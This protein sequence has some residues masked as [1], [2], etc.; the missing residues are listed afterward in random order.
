MKNEENLQRAAEAVRDAGAL[1]VCAGAGMGVDSGLPD[2]RGDKGFWK[3]YPPYERLGLGFI[4]MANPAWFVRDPGIGWGF[5][6]HRLQL[7]RD[8]VPH[9]GFEI[10]RSWGESMPGGAFVFTSNVDGQFQKAGFGRDRIEECHGSIHH[11]Q[12]CRPCH[13]DIWSA[14]GVTVEVEMETMCAQEP[15][16]SC[17][18]CGALARPNILMFGDAGWLQDRTGAQSGRLGQWLRDQNDHGLVVVECGAGTA[19]P[20]VRYQSEHVVQQYGAT[21]IRVNLREPQVPAGQIG[22]PLGALEA[23]ERMDELTG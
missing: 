11:L 6:G 14:E 7:Y 15:H 16:P 17:P 20:S 9:R 4:S 2:F 22:L 10:L 23:L 18:Q 13:S 19:V 21:L 1:L 3:A 5:Y 12:C 8:T